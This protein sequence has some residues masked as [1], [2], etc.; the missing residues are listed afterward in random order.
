MPSHSAISPS[1][2]IVTPVHTIPLAR[3]TSPTAV[4]VPE[5]EAC[6]GALTNFSVSPIF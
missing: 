1:D 2:S 5:M 3:R 4:T 6:T